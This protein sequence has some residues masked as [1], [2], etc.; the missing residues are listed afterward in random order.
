MKSSQGDFRVENH[1]IRWADSNVHTYLKIK[2]QLIYFSFFKNG[3]NRMYKC[4]GHTYRHIHL[5]A[6]IYTYTHIYTH[7]YSLH[8]HTHKYVVLGNIFIYPKTYV[9]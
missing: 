2:I 9:K 5:Y 4:Q 3:T 1:G 6:H 8:T 7:I